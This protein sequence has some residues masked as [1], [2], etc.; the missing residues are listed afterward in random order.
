[1][2]GWAGTWYLK[3]A[4][5]AIGVG[6]TTAV[7]GVLLAVVMLVVAVRVPELL[8]YSGIEEGKA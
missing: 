8:R 7:S 5:E 2:S 6:P 1:M 4:A 3:N